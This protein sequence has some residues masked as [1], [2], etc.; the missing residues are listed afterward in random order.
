MDFVMIVEGK[1]DRKKLREL[2]LD[3]IEILC[4]YGTPSQP[5]IEKIK[6]QV[7][8]RHVFI[9]TDHD[10]PGKRIRGMLREA[11]PDAEQLYTKTGYAGVEGTPVEHIIHQLE[12]LQLHEYIR[13]SVLD[14][15]SLEEQFQYKDH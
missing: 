8:D 11:F 13:N 10:A 7:G 1:N 14:E 6:E 4:T 2:L 5:T 12:K 15:L 9:F 3:E